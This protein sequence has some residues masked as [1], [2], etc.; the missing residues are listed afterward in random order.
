MATVVAKL[1]ESERVPPMSGL[2]ARGLLFAVLALGGCAVDLWTKAAVFEARGLPGQRPP[3]WLW[4]G[5][6]GIETAVNTGAVFGMGAGM[7]VFFA[8]FSAI[9]GICVLTWLFY[10]GAARE[11]W[12]LIA[13]G[14]VAGGILGNLYDRLGL[15]WEPGMPT[16]WRS[17]V[18]DWILWQINDRW[19]WPNFNIADSLLVSGA[20]ML[21][22]RALFPVPEATDQICGLEGSS[23]KP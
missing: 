1:A 11:W 13:L 17:A 15:W 5:H 19:K 4:E 12:L 2:W 7:G 16:E 6:V 3:L 20:V 18:R 21:V 9:A 23:Q 8:L 14:C 22:Y 10:F